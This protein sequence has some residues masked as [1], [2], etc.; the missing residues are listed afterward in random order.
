M[1]PGLLRTQATLEQSRTPRAV[2]ASVPTMLAGL[3]GLVATSPENPELLE[4]AARADA[5]FAFTFLEEEDPAW[6]K[7]LYE[8]AQDH[9]RRALEVRDAPLLAQVLS[10]VDERPKLGPVAESDVPALFWLAFAWGSRI[11]L[12]R[13][14]PRLLRQLGQVDR[15]MQAVLEKDETFF[16]GGP[17]LYFAVRHGCLPRLLGGD[18]ARARRH[19][20]AVERINGGRH[21]FAKLL[22]AQ[23]LSCAIPDEKAAWEDFHATLVAIVDA[24]DDLWPEQRLAN[25][26]AKERA[27]RLGARPSDAN[28][29]EP[30]GAVNRFAE[31][32]GESCLAR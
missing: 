14:D 10:P 1:L 25:E 11:N 18:P 12:D 21:L 22:R 16:Y 2:K 8:K 24:P 4:L 7:E 31:K 30:E 6:A 3:E 26:V 29:I 17:H 13:S 15:A 19:L 28:I 5:M 9:A 23:Y 27:R 20:D 32:G